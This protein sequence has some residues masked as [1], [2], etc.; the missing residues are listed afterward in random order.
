MNRERSFAGLL[1]QALPAPTDT[2]A[3]KARVRARLGRRRRRGPR[4]G[5]RSAV[6]AAA[7]VACAAGLWA[8]LPTRSFDD[9]RGPAVGPSTLPPAEPPLAR[10]RFSAGQQDALHQL[11]GGTL[12]LLRAG[13]SLSCEEG[14]AEVACRLDSGTVLVHV[15]K[16]GSRGLRI[17]AGGHQVRVTGTVFGVTAGDGS[18]TGLVVW[19]GSV[20][21]ERGRERHEVEAGQAWGKLGSRLHAT[22]EDIRRLQATGRLA[23]PA[24]AVA[25]PPRAQP[26]TAEVPAASNAPAAGTRRAQRARPVRRAAPSPYARA[27]RREMEGAL[28]EAAELY[29]QV[30]S[31]SE[32]SAEAALF[33]AARI[34]HGLGEHEKAK[35]L[36]LRHRQRFPAGPFAR[37]VDVLLLRAYVAVGDDAAIA[38]E[39]DRFLRDHPEDPRATHFLRARAHGL[40]ARGRCEEAQE[41][42]WR[43]PSAD[44]MRVVA[45]CR[46]AAR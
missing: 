40:A 28:T 12:V 21:L 41:L 34:R 33:A 42:A 29:E 16:H 7:T 20:V 13:S 30:G 35:A 8:S 4:L 11:A 1:Q 17:D 15:P 24:P 36:L 19:E 5:L 22:A 45:R 27:R 2:A 39:A 25:E 10:Q 44:R 6:W 9:P 23:E 14:E 46:P 38:A 32:R 3:A 18:L 26:G 37:A 31:S 43:L